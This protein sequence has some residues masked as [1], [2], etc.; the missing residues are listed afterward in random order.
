MRH[1]KRLLGML[2]ASSMGLTACAAQGKITDNGS[3]IVFQ[4]QQEPDKLNPII[5]D[6]MATIDAGV[7]LTGAP[8]TTAGN[9]VGGSV[10]GAGNLIAG[11]DFGVYIDGSGF[12]VQGNTIGANVTRTSGTGT[13]MGVELAFDSDGNTIGG[14]VADTDLVLGNTITFCATGVDSMNSRLGQRQCVPRVA[15]FSMP[16]ICSSADCGMGATTTAVR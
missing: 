5:S 16:T 12:V 4:Q 14:G 2:L 1:G 6:M 8:G 9:V 11:T 7:I 3:T 13:G 10:A 15:A